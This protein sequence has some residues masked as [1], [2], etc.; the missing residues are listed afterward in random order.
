MKSHLYFILNQR[1]SL[2]NSLFATTSLSNAKFDVFISPVDSVSMGEAGNTTGGS[3]TVPLT[4]CLTGL[5]L[6][7]LQIK[8]KIVSS[9]TDDSKPV[10]QE[11]NC[12]VIPPPLVFPGWGDKM[13]PKPEFTLDSWQNTFDFQSFHGQLTTPPLNMDRCN[14]SWHLPL[15]TRCQ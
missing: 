2:T 1:K 12:T 10:K 3:I 7:V 4:S 6:S 14:C 15:S 13:A 5:D 9:H 11:V 8:T